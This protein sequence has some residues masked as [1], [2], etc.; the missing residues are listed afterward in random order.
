MEKLE[1]SCNNVE[2]LSGLGILN[3]P[4]EYH[5]RLIDIQNYD[6][7]HVDICSSIF[8]LRRQKKYTLYFKEH[9]I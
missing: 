6:P 3:S 7:S 4:G 1:I 9:F 8:R 2:K 5:H